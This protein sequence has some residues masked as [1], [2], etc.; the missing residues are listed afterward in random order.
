MA[1]AIIAGLRGIKPVRNTV[2]VGVVRS[3]LGIACAVAVRV[4]VEVVGDAVAI[5]VTRALL[6]V[7]NVVIVRVRISLVRD[8]VAVGVGW[9]RW[10]WWR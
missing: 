10:N 5:R 1:L 3:L 6:G 7:G 9:G 8:A 2:A 4:G